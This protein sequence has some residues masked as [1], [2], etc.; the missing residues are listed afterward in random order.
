MCLGYD[1]CGAFS[2]EMNEQATMN[3][4]SKISDAALQK[5]GIHT[6]RPPTFPIYTTYE[7]RL[8]SFDAWP[9]SMK[10]KPAAL[11]DAGFF[12]TGKIAYIR[13]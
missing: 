8:K 5:F 10:L 3:T 1:V 9:I 2:H 11:S 6:N 13:I 4:E 12:Y 7:A